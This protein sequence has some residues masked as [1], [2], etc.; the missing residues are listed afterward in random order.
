MVPWYLG[1]G[2]EKILRLTKYGLEVL[3][4][5]RIGRRM[6]YLVL[7]YPIF[8]PIKVNKWVKL[9]TSIDKFYLF[10][11]INMIVFAA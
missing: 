10:C 6:F 8:D 4:F 1:W 11:S 7:G 3:F 2:G 5:S 9:G